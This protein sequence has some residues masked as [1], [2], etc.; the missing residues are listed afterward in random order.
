[1]TQKI[2]SLDWQQSKV[3]VQ[4]EKYIFIDYN[5]MFHSFLGIL[6]AFLKRWYL[7]WT[8]MVHKYWIFVWGLRLRVPLWQLLVHDCSKFCSDEWCG[9]LNLHD[10]T[11]DEYVNAWLH[12][13]N[14][15]EHHYQYWVLVENG[16]MNPIEMPERYVREM[17]CDWIA[18]NKVYDSSTKLLDFNYF[19]KNRSNMLS[20]MHPKTIDHIQNVLENDLLGYDVDNRII[21]LFRQDVQ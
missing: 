6:D 19:D 13:Q 4:K 20:C 5:T 1:M 8:I 12:H 14:H 21:E 16:T 17:V 15:N 9:Y 2:D 7:F 10:K 18:A 11:S 3:L